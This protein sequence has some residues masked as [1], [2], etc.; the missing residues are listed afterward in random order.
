VISRATLGAKLEPHWSNNPVHKGI[1][2]GNGWLEIIN[3]LVDDLVRVS[4]GF[5]IVQ[6]KQKFG[7]LR[8]YADDV[9]EAGRDLIWR[10]EAE[11]DKTCELC[12]SLATR[13]LSF[14]SLCE[15]DYNKRIREENASLRE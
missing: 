4:P 11:A 10:A 15:N 8:F 12:G 9:N 6:I 14:T 3:K 13:K 2:C 7:G 1:D 5:K